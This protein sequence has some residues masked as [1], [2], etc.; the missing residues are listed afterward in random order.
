MD[1][2]NKLK[3]NI[4]NREYDQTLDL[5]KEIIQLMERKQNT[6]AETFWEC[7]KCKNTSRF[8]ATSG[9]TEKQVI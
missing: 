4:H 3:N 7:R 1:T 5:E 9:N 8:N 6:I 2:E